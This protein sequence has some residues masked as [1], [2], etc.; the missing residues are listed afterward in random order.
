MIY[1]PDILANNGGW[2]NTASPIVS[3]E[4]DQL[5]MNQMM[6]SNSISPK[7]FI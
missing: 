7:L 4:T 3:P 1:L 6:P 5:K 2:T